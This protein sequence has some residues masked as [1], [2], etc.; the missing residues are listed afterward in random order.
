ME[1]TSAF[2]IV[3]GVEKYSAGDKWNLDG[4]AADAL[5]FTQWLVGQK[6]PQQNIRVF[7]SPLQPM[8][9]PEEVQ[10]ELATRHNISEAIRT[11]LATRNEELFFFFWGGHGVI[12][13]DF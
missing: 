3:V 11:T 8:S 5:R 7:A 6:V 2:A 10:V 1:P 12:R 9:F 4:P 13:E